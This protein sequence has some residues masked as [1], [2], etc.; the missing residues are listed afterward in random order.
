M[1]KKTKRSKRKKSVIT[2][3]VSVDRYINLLNRQIFEQKY[4]EAVANGER[5]LN[6]LPQHAPQ[7]VDVLA[8]LA[9]A[10]A[11]LQNFPQAYDILT[12]ALT[13]DPKNADLLYNRSMVGR[14]TGRIGQSL[15]DIER[16]IELNTLSELHEKLSEALQLNLELAEKSMQLRGPNFTL[17]QLVEQEDHFQ[18][19]LKFMESGNWEEAGQAFQASIDMGDCLP[20]PWGNLG[21]C[22]MMQERYDEAE[23]ALKRAIAID[24]KYTIAKNNLAALPEFRRTGPPDVIGINEPFRNVKMKQSLTFIRE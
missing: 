17:D 5:L 13:L 23:S 18:Q 24:P 6:S 2:T 22:L 20:Q 9:I 1:T 10:H 21:L 8:Q 11:M 4:A 15:Y 19:G 14:F 12:E 16:A 7:R 3:S